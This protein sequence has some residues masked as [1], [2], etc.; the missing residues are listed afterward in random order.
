MSSFAAVLT[1]VQPPARTTLCVDE[2]FDDLWHYKCVVS[3]R[4]LE[5]IRASCT[6]VIAGVQV[7]KLTPDGSPQ[8]TLPV[9]PKSFY[10][11]YQADRK[12]SSVCCNEF[13]VTDNSSHSIAEPSPRASCSR[14]DEPT[15]VEVDPGSPAD[16]CAALAPSASGAKL[17]AV[18]ATESEIFPAPELAACSISQAERQRLQRVF[19]VFDENRDGKI[20]IEELGKSFEKVG[21]LK[22]EHAITSLLE[23]MTLKVE[24]HVDEDEFVFLY[25]STCNFIDEF[26][27][28]ENTSEMDRDLREAFKLFDTD[29]NGFISPTELQSVL[30][31]LGF[32]QAQELDAC[33]KMINRVDE[34]GDG[35]VD[36]YEFKKMLGV[37]D[38][39]LAIAC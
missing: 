33:V 39:P 1:L 27:N 30:C 11:K 24:G 19:H 36:F 22:T 26:D 13:S 10:L 25:M 9:L 28:E 20:S 17:D 4:A 14:T 38:Q 21:I 32:P 6:N 29:K 16:I 31:G 15:F 34:N 18:E 35:Q 12:T 3:P 2:P 37:E 8:S 7:Q 5:K 23:T